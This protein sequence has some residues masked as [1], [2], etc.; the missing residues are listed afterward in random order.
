MENKKIN[1]YPGHMF[2]AKKEIQENLKTI[3]AIIEVIDSRCPIISHNKM[4]EEVVSSKPKLLIFSKADLVEKKDL[5]KYLDYYKELGYKT[6]SIDIRQ[7]NSKDR[8]ISQIKELCDPIVKK[9][10]KK[11]INKTLRVMIIGMP[12]VGK[13]TLI[14][15]LANKK[16]LIV[17]NRPG[18]TK[19][20]QVIKVTDKIELVDTPGILIP[21]IEK[22]HDGYN[23]VL[24]S[25]IK[26][27]VVE[28]EEIAFYLLKYLIENKKEVLLNRYSK[29][30]LEDITDLEMSPNE[31]ENMYEKIGKS[32]GAF[33][34]HTG[35]DY[36][37]VSVRLI[38]DYRFQKFGKI[39]LDSL[40]E[41][42]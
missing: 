1:W 16:K 20:Q 26:D 35:V 27:E 31:I 39:I 18:V 32:I 2:K 19:T 17:G 36:N 11:Q 22:L 25:L 40:D 6:F 12:N 3:D 28:I 41:R 5:N 4:L 24:N 15:T 7:T 10:E 13:S 33:S 21:K 30:L 9:Y 38:A 8:I 42:F 37:K 29:L 14:N 23:L 34:N